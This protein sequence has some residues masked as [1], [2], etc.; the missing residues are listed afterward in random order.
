M[1]RWCKARL[2]A[3]GFEEKGNHMENDASTCAPKTLKLCVAKIM[4][5][6]WMVKTLD[7]K[8]AY[9]QGKE[10]ERVVYLKLLKKLA[11]GACGN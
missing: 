10:I 6:G 7:M 5:E 2:G 9:L 3:R 4:Q 1:K 8:K 11:L